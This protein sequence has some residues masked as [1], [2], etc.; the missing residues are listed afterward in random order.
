MAVG[1]AS[2]VDGL[3]SVL[4]AKYT[5]RGQLDRSFSGDGFRVIERAVEIVAV[6]VL[7]Q[8]DGKFL[9]LLYGEH[10][11]NGVLRLKCQRQDR[12]D[13]RRRRRDRR[14]AGRLADTR[15]RSR[16][17]P[18]RRGR[19]RVW[20]D[21]RRPPEAERR[22]ID[23]LWRR[24]RSGRRGPH[25]L[26]HG[27]RALLMSRCRM[28]RPSSSPRRMATSWSSVSRPAVSQTHPSTAGSASSRSAATTRILMTNVRVDGPGRIRRCRAAR[29][30]EPGTPTRRTRSS[31]GSCPSRAVPARSAAAHGRPPGGSIHLGPLRGR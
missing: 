9:V 2:V 25:E 16:R 18:C 1:Y 10:Q 17:Y 22:A 4:I 14:P 21:P 15:A 11:D 26:R 8:S 29:A 12:S 31:I 30:G 23:Q 24:G 7:V 27:G 19:R 28:T 20:R 13:V 6:D 5:A 3:L